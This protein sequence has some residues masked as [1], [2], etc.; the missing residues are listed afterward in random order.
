MIWLILVAVVFVGGGA[1][2]VAKSMRTRIIVAVVGAAAVAG[3]W[4]IGKP[5]MPDDPLSGQI[6]QIEKLAQNDPDKLTAE[7]FMAL[8]EKRAHD[9]PKDPMPHWIMGQVLEASGRPQEAMMA[10]ESALRRDPNH[11]PTIKNLADLRFKMTGTV[12]PAT[13]ALYHAAYK[14]EPGNLR[15]GYMAGIGDW[16]EGNKEEAEAIWKGVETSPAMDDTHRQM[17]AAMRQMFK[18]D[19]G[20]PETPAPADGAKPSQKGK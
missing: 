11:L 18:I 6:E 17:F 12:D 5:N 16:L 10:Y 19:A 3:Y 1:W 14:A 13:S 20:A 7:Q 9:N 15:M 4:F 2:F 8:A